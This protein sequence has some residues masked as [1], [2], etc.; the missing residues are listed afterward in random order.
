MALTMKSH[1]WLFPLHNQSHPK[2][3]LLR[4]HFQFD[5]VTKVTQGYHDNVSIGVRMIYIWKHRLS[6]KYLVHSKKRSVCT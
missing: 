6:K 2:T 4:I 3:A 5:F 1:F